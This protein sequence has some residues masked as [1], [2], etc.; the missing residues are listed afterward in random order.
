MT[1]QHSDASYDRTELT[2]ALLNGSDS[3]AFSVTF[4][5]DFPVSF[6]DQRQ[7]SSSSPTPIT[8]TPT[9]STSAST[10]DYGGWSLMVA[11]I[12]VIVA[13]LALLVLARKKRSA[14]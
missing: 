4:Q 9:A 3:E 12:I 2:W 10:N 13:T 7:I 1:I 5:K 6:T 11:V 8:P 14:P